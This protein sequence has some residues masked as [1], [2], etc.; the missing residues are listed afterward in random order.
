MREGGKG[1][2]GSI[3]WPNQLDEGVG[4]VEV[5]PE[6]RSTKNKEKNCGGN[7]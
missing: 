1:R 6:N 5:H 7:L 2:R 3:T 4:R